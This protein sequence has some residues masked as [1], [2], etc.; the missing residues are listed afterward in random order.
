MEKSLRAEIGARIAGEAE[1]EVQ[2]DRG[3][4]RRRDIERCRGRQ[5]L[6]KNIVFFFLALVCVV[7]CLFF[8]HPHR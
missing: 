7:F 4:S 1:T 6:G 5:A 3:T 2:T 8:R